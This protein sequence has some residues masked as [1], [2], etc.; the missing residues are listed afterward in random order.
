MC[1]GEGMGSILSPLSNMSPPRAIKAL[2]AGGLREE[3]S[4]WATDED[5]GGCQWQSR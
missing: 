2:C 1:V 4:H 3:G 5:L